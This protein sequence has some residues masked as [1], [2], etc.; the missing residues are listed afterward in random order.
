MLSLQVQ[1]AVA[2]LARNG[3]NLSLFRPARQTKQ[4][5]DTGD[6]ASNEHPNGFVSRRSSKEPGKI[7]AER[8]GGLKPHD[9]EHN[10][11][12]QQ[13]NRDHFIHNNL[14]ITSGLNFALVDSYLLVGHG[15]LGFFHHDL[16]AVHGLSHS[17]LHGFKYL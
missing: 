3:R 12:D 1:C 13:N 14:S 9:H 17:V 4:A 11:T 8:V 5:D 6:N 10:S 2:R 15:Q 7:R 16:Y